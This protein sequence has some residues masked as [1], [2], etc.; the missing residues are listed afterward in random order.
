MADIPISKVCTVCKC[1]KPTTDFGKHKQGRGGLNPQCKQCNR[2]RVA[3]YQAAKG[4]EYKT[5]K[6]AYDKQRRDAGLVPCRRAWRETNRERLARAKAAWAAA[7]PEKVK[8]VKV[9]YKHRRRALEAGGVS[10][11]ELRIW[12]RAQRQVCYW[13]GATQAKEYTIDHYV[14][15]ARGGKHVIGNLVVACRPC[16]VRK[17]AKDPLEFARQ[18]GRLL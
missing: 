15:L 5:R 9:A 1:A 10:S 12:W 18:I 6:R 8:W 11:R 13:C 14:P 16:N 2:E 4:A 3:A 17:N 7:H